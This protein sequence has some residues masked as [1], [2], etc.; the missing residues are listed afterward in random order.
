M[1][2]Y[3]LPMANEHVLTPAA[4]EKL[5]QELE[6]LRGS[7]RTRI[8]EA[9]REAKSHG[10]LRENAAYHEAKLNQAR[11]EKRI[12]DLEKKYMLARVV[13]AEAAEDG[14]AQLGSLVMLFDV[15]FEE[16]FEITLVSSYEANPSESKIS[17]T[18]PLGSALLGKGIGEHIEVEAPAGTQRYRLDGIQ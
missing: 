16:V 10:D 1:L 11:L 3:E 13:E 9:I 17:I 2:Q 6:F 4:Y 18:S 5:R 12:A 15:E 8:A 7:E 14:S